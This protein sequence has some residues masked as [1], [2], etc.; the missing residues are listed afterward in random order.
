VSEPP[1][2]V[3]VRVIAVKV[4]V[5][6]RVRVRARVRVGVTVPVVDVVAH[7]VRPPL[8]RRVWSGWGWEVVVSLLR[9][10]W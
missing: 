10:S 6:V 7:V 2:R 9:L 1:P 4:R 8:A 3:R 5:R